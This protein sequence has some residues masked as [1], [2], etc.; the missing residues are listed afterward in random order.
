VAEVY[1]IDNSGTGLTA[2]TA[3]TVIEISNS[4]T[5]ASRLIELVLSCDYV[6]IATPLFIKVEFILGTSGTG[7]AY[8]PKKLNGEAQNRAA[9]TTAKIN[10]TV[11]PTSVTVLRTMG[12]VVPGG[13][14]ALQ[15]PLGRETY[16]NVN[17]M[18]GIRCTC[19]SAITNVFASA[20]IE[21]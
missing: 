20:L 14:L 10:D 9:G 1:G 13:P 3:K 6:T 2:A 4:T 17:N 7:T 18:L 8:T 19:A 12:F 5:T 21:E 16:Y 11:E 15:W